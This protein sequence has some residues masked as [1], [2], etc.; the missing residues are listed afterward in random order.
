MVA[1]FNLLKEFFRR[2]QAP[3]LH[4]LQIVEAAYIRLCVD[5][6]GQCLPKMQALEKQKKHIFQP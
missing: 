6:R 2:E 5:V 4:F 1:R 3:A